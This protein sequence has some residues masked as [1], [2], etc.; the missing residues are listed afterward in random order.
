MLVEDLRDRLVVERLAL[1]DVAP[2]AR[3]VADG[4]E[5]ELAFFLRLG[6]GFGA[7]RVPVGRVVGMHQEI[8]TRL[9]GE[10]IGVLGLALVLGFA[11][12]EGTGGDCGEESKH[13]E[14]ACAAAHRWLR[15][16]ISW[17]RR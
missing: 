6:E 13:P 7:P 12:S 14:E 9:L 16:R 5:N 10:P 11:G 3:A 8:R 17:P 15:K 4:E 1:H 2:V